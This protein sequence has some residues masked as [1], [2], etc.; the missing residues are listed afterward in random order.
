MLDGGLADGLLLH[1]RLLHWRLL[2]RG[3]AGDG[4]DAGSRIV[5]HDRRG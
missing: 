3:L 1:W 4:D 5:H 2:N